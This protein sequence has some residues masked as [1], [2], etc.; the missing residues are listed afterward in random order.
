MKTMLMIRMMMENSSTAIITT[1]T[2]APCILHFHSRVQIHQFKEH[3]CATKRARQ[4]KSGS[5][6][7]V[8]EKEGEQS[9]GIGWG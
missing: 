3:V 6:E 5:S 9:N 7:R 2:G 1:S 4:K 8:S